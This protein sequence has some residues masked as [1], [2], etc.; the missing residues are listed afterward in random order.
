LSQ[1]LHSRVMSTVV[2]LLDFSDTPSISKYKM[3]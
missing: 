2:C 3:F 1:L